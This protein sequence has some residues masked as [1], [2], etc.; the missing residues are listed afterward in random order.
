MAFKLARTLGYVG[1][2]RVVKNII[3]SGMKVLAFSWEAKNWS[4]ANKIGD[5]FN[6]S[7]NPE[8]H[9]MEFCCP[10]FMPYILITDL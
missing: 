1:S 4:Q 7:C 3:M 5:G 6:Y 8:K 10:K 2:L 9:L